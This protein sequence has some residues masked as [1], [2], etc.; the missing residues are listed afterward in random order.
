MK[1]KIVTF[2]VTKENCSKVPV[3]GVLPFDSLCDR[4][5]DGPAD[6]DSSRS[7]WLKLS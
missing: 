6:P 2:P 7:N 3:V 4:P 5:A 1:N